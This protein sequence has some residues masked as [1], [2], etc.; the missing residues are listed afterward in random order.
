M[1]NDIMAKM[2]NK[3]KQGTADNLKYINLYYLTKSIRYSQLLLAYS[4]CLSVLAQRPIGS[5]A[6]SIWHN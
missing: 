1:A 6:L 2:S 4:L 3:K 5:L